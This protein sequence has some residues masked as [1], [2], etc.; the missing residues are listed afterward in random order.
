MLNLKILIGKI[1]V[2]KSHKDW[3]VWHK[4]LKINLFFHKFW[5]QLTNEFKSQ[6]V[7]LI[8]DGVNVIEV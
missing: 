1:L 7:I 5:K 2:L 8:I 3:Q 4:N 6:K